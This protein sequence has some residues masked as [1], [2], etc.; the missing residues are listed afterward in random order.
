[1][2]NAIW[3]VLAAGCL[4]FS[5]ARASAEEL[6]LW[7]VGAGV[8]GLSFPAYR[9]SDQSRQFLMPVPFFAYRGEFLKA[10][11]NGVRG[12]IF[13]TEHLDM[14]VSAAL[15]PP[16]FSDDV[17]ARAGM[18]DLEATFEVGPQ[19]NVNLWKS[20][21]EQ[22][23]LRLLL[24]VRKAYTLERSPQDLGWVFHPKLNLDIRDAPGME[25]WNLGLLAGPLFGDRRQHSHFYSVASSEAIA[26]RPAY[27]APGGF[28]G[29]QYLVAVSRRFP[30]YWV[31]GFV[32][33]DNLRGAAF[34]NSPLVR[35]KNYWAAGFAVSW[36]L[37]Q[38]SRKVVVGD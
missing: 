9:G 38:S 5:G 2:K 31:G 20:D 10:D 29:M 23:H 8:A 18:A 27:A 25:G 24:P 21:N 22:R 4:L 36:I 28:A 3:S 11:R 12:Q 33:Y 34:E 37:G 26:G 16:A 15:S 17:Q 1:M 6:P 14:T 32:R 30:R 35:D 7:E 19:L 13:K